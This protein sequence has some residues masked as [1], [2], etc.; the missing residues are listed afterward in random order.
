MVEVIREVG[1]DAFPSFVRS[2]LG[3]RRERFL[4]GRRGRGKP[5]R[6]YLTDIVFDDN[7]SPTRT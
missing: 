7:S 3:D 2:L 4:K 5:H 6:R 1:R